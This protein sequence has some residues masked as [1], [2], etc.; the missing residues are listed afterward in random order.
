[1]NKARSIVNVI[2]QKLLTKSGI[3]FYE[4]A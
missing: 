2:D 1:M 3:F 4:Y